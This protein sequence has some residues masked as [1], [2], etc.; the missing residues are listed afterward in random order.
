MNEKRRALTILDLKE[1]KTRGKKITCLTAYDAS[2]GCL[3]DSV[4]IDVV[5]VGDSL[6]MVI[7]G[8][9]STL[10]VTVDEMIYHTRSVAKAVKRAWLIADLPFMSYSTLEQAA[11]NAGRLMSEG[12]ASMVKLEGGRRCADIIRHLT[13]QGIPVCAHLGLTPQSI[14]QLGGYRIQGREQD[15]ANKMIEDACIL[16][17]AGA[18]MLVLEC[19][20]RGLASDIS[21]KISIPTIGIGAGEN[22]DGQVLVLH[23]MLGIGQQPLPKFTKNF[24]AGEQS[25]EAAVKAYRQAVQSVEFPGQE[26]GFE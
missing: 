22:C 5:L 4:G 14:H 1:M 3:L 12:Y 17:K 19:I 26:H 18:S 24:L 10:S 25:I 7:K 6:G 20:P 21:Q 15:A 8:E 13:E 9:K 11:S 2:F 16:E 23:D